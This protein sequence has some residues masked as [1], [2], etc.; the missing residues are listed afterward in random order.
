MKYLFL[1][2]LVALAVLV[3]VALYRT[4]SGAR[5][6]EGF[7]VVLKNL[8]PLSCP[9]TGWLV[10]TKL[11]NNSP[12][13]DKSVTV[14]SCQFINL[15]SVV[16]NNSGE[17]VMQLKLPLSLATGGQIVLPLTHN[18][19]VPISLGDSNNDNII[20]STDQTVVKESLFK[21]NPSVDFNSDGRVSIEDYL[22]TKTHQGVGVER[23]DGRSW[24]EFK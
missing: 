18:L 7:Q 21:S 12:I 14:E 5:N 3:G 9:Q 11:G 20:D 10:V 24:Q 4:Q 8:P 1:V 15:S 16:G 19:E 22:L 17:Y 6:E 13:V 23:I 2:T